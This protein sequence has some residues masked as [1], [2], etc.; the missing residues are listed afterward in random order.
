MIELLHPIHVRLNVTTN[1][2]IAGCKIYIKEVLPKS[3]ADKDGSLK[4][5]DLVLRINGTSLDGLT[6][7][8]ARKVVEAAKERLDFMIR[9]PPSGSEHYLT[10]A[11]PADRNNTGGAPPRPP[12]PPWQQQQ[13][14]GKDCVPSDNNC[15]YN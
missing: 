1:F 8:D 3:V 15:V 2:L 7:K 5:G 10:S 14:E 12:M 11:D 6:L 9:R 13:N 4:A